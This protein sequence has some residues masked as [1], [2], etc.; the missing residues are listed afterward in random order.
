MWMGHLGRPQCQAVTPR[1]WAAGPEA[2]ACGQGSVWIPRTSTPASLLF[3]PTPNGKHQAT[4]RSSLGQTS[5]RLALSSQEV[6]ARLLLQPEW[7]GW[8]GS[9]RPGPAIKAEPEAGTARP[10]ARPRPL[11]LRSPPT[12]SNS[13]RPLRGF[14]KLLTPCSHHQARL[15]TLGWRWRWRHK[16]LNW[17]E[18]GWQ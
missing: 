2:V 4:P 16:H 15:C 6:P 1:G 18:A 5:S 9:G 13:E 12:A 7:A 14:P 17:H 8:S 3:H 11:S 10:A